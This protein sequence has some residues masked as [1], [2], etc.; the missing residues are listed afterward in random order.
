MQGQEE[1]AGLEGLEDGCAGGEGQGDQ[2]V[3]G[4]GLLLG[5]GGDGERGQVGRVEGWGRARQ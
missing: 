4:R 5:R 2:V 1:A 3:Y